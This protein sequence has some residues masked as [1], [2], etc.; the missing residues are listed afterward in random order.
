LSICF[1]DSTRV[2]ERIFSFFALDSFKEQRQCFP[3][4]SNIFSLFSPV[5]PES[6]TAPFSRPLSCGSPPLPPSTSGFQ[7]SFALFLCNLL[8]YH[9][10]FRLPFSIFG[11][12]ILLQQLVFSFCDLS[13]PFLEQKFRTP[14]R[15]YIRLLAAIQVY[16]SL[17]V[18]S[19]FPLTTLSVCPVS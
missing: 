11:D 7:R 15:S 4:A 3:C 18:C 1:S 8:F 16:T 2:I 10:Y 19:P 17:I 13:P 9:M 12:N 6:V 14:N 5:P